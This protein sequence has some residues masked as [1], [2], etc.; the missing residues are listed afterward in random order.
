MFSRIARRLHFE[1]ANVDIVSDIHK[2]TSVF[3]LDY[4]DFIIPL[5]QLSSPDSYHVIAR[6]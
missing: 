1:H 6:K 2:L 5:G 4:F 3:E